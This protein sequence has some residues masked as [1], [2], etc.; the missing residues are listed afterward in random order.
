MKDATK[1]RIWT[2]A[3][4]AEA[5]LAVVVEALKRLH[6]AA[7]KSNCD[8][9]ACDNA[10]DVLANIPA[11]SWIA[12]REALIEQVG[13][14]QRAIGVEKDRAE[15]A[16]SELSRLKST[17]LPAGCVAVCN[18]AHCKWTAGDHCR[19]RPGIDVGMEFTCSNDGANRLRAQPE[20][21]G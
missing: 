11:S 6:H 15:K 12:E 13:L 18:V 8:S 1:S 19:M 21:E 3:E 4:T 14:M 16:E 9:G 17:Q 10:R 20:R 7:D 2:R 5:S